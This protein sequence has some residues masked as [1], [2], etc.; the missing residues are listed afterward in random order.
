MIYLFEN[1]TGFYLFKIKNEK[2]KKISSYTFS[3]NDEL[4]ETYK[5][6]D[7]SNLPE[8]LVSFLKSEFEKL[9]DILAVRDSRLANTITEKCSIS[10]KFIQDDIFRQ[11]IREIEYFSTPDDLLKT[12]YLSHKLSLEKIKYDS[13]KLDFMIIQSINL[14]LDIDKDINLHC[15]R[16]REWYGF[17]FPELSLVVDD[18]FLYVRI[19]SVLKNKL[20]FKKDDLEEVAGD[21]TDR[22]IHLSKNS[23]GTDISDE[24]ID[25]IIN[26]CTSV[27]K[28][29]EYRTNLSKYIKEKMIVVAPNITNLI[30]DF[31][32]A[33][34]IS[35]AGSLC[36]LAKYPGSTVQLLGAE[37]SLFQAL[38][39]QSNTPKY[40]IIFE[41]S[42]LGQVPPEYKG[43]VAR[44]LASKISLCAK[45]D[46]LGKNQTGEF[47]AECKKK[48]INRIRNL[49]NSSKPKKKAVKKSKFI[50]NIDT[51]YDD[52][53]DVKRSKKD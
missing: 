2:I 36:G 53:K 25:N 50:L 27:I 32:G 33:R 45:I 40:G 49:E 7:T 34:L 14:L 37:K 19:V 31:M 28:N 39:N 24:D 13:D 41:S 16:I 48:I 52:K 6:L 21:L 22:I 42:L 43:K 29:F 38:R 18:N 10:T 23:M 12:L 20:N 3:N 30:G 26:D 44:T 11:I 15:M 46:A 8:N 17:H 51:K 1:S 4:L 9:D 47:G 35:K 5:S